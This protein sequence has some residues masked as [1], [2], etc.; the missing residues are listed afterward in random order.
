MHVG[1]FYRLGTLTE[2]M[3]KIGGG[4]FLVSFS[5]DVLV[6]VGGTSQYVPSIRIE[7]IWIWIK[8][9]KMVSSLG[10]SR[11]HTTSPNVRLGRCVVAITGVAIIPYGGN[12][13]GTLMKFPTIG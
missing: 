3:G 11:Y 13:N 9:S 8:W 12:K 4:P 7:S 1:A 10:G 6:V 2:G 5:M